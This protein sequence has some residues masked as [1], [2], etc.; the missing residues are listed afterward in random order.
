MMD[1]QDCV[2]VVDDDAMIA[3][4]LCM[5]M[6]DMGLRVCGNAATADIA[7]TMAHLHRPRLVL[8]DVRLRGE[9]DG[10]DA[11]IVIHEKVGSKIIYVTGSREPSTT[12]RIGLDH[13]TAVLFKPISERQ[14]QTAVRDAMVP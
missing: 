2:L 13:P 6:E 10:V 4:F 12:A 11:A 14:L 1:L 9:R 3:D 5:V 7:I 8:M